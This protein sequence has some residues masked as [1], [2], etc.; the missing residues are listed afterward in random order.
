MEKVTPQEKSTFKIKL[1]EFEKYGLEKYGN[2]L[3]DQLEF[4][5]KSKIRA[6][7]KKYV[8]NQIIMN[9]AKIQKIENKLK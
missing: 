7:Y 2:Y 8:E 1:L 3:Q 5:S 6:S 4:A 9:N